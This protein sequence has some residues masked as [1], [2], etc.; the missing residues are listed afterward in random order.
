MEAFLKSLYNQRIQLE[1]TLETTVRDS[2]YTDQLVELMQQEEHVCREDIT[3][4]AALN[5][6]EKVNESLKLETEAFFHSV[7]KQNSKKWKN[8]LHK[9]EKERSRNAAELQNYQTTSS[10]SSP[11]VIDL[12]L[13]AL[14][15]DEE[16]NRNWFSHE[17]FSLQEAF[18]TQALKIEA[19]WSTHEK[20]LLKEYNRTCDKILG[21]SRSPN[22]AANTAAVPTEDARWQHP[23]KQKSLIHTAP[24][25]TPTKDAIKTK[26][27]ASEVR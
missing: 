19:D 1:L 12:D 14:R 2:K 13:E 27:T 26:H 21:R 9:L 17:G 23:E 11:N 6:H 10:Q 25:M 4:T 3:S 7:A 8:L 18:K 22:H 15:L 16:Y 24:V 5:L 20:D